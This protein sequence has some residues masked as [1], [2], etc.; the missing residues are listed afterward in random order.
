MERSVEK[1][2]KTENRMKDQKK[3]GTTP[4]PSV[5]PLAFPA[6]EPPSIQDP[7]IDPPVPNRA[8]TEM[9]L[10]KDLDALTEA[11]K[12]DRYLGRDSVF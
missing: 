11:E 6:T 10:G 12:R 3:N 4:M 2:K 8:W 5:P 9:R 7:I 1:Q